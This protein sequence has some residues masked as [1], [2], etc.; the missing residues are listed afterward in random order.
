[1]G[2]SSRSTWT[3]QTKA[4]YLFPRRPAFL[5]PW[6]P[7]ISRWLNFKVPSRNLPSEGA[8]IPC[9][10]LKREDLL[11]VRFAFSRMTP[12]SAASLRRRASL[13]LVLALM[14]FLWDIGIFT[15]SYREALDPKLWRRRSVALC[16]CLAE[17][18]EVL[19]CWNRCDSLRR[20]CRSRSCF[21][22]SVS[23]SSS[24]SASAFALLALL[25]S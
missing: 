15:C 18:Q 22:L 23:D 17:F 13:A 8:S 2:A 20:R 6:I 3:L 19:P 11:G 24:G 10:L 5:G 21:K 9:S 7:A 4:N 1:M 12:F 25:A 14:P 16:R